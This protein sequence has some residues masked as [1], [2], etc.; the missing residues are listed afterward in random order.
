M[1]SKINKMVFMC[2]GLMMVMATLAPRSAHAMRFCQFEKPR[3]I[4]KMATTKTRYVRDQSARDLTE[5]H[6]GRSGNNIGGLGG[7]E[8][9]YKIATKYNIMS[10]R[11]K[12]CVGLEA[13]KVTFYGKPEVHIASNFKRGSCEYTAVLGHEQIHIRTM[14][15]FMREYAPKFK[16]EV[17]RIAKSSR[18]H[19]GPIRENQIEEA[20]ADLQNAYVQQLSIYL[21]KVLPILGQRQKKV[22]SPE[23][24]DRV[25]AKCKNWNRKFA[26]SK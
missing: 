25:F 26:Q 19:I 23:E 13:V 11:G 10:Q 24:Y 18:R 20:Q 2:L 15:K 7:G 22:D 14:R 21:G 1:V 9:G 17:A 3:V 8:I 4:V 5:M 16:K 12:H 6:T